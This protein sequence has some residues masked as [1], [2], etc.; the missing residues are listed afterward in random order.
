MLKRSLRSSSSKIG[1]C[2]LTN[3]YFLVPLNIKP[4][5]VKN[6]YRIQFKPLN[7]KKMKRTVTLFIVFITCISLQGQNSEV[8]NML[9]EIEGQWSLDDNSNV[10]YQRIVEVPEMK[11]D[12]IYDRVLNYF[13]YNYG[14]GKSVIQTQDN[15]KGLVI[16]KG[17]YDRLHTFSNGT[18][19]VYLGTW[20]IV[21]VD[22]K[23]GRA[24]IIITLTEYLEDYKGSLSTTNVS[25][26]FPINKDGSRKN[27]MG[28]AFYKSHLRVIETLESIEKAI[29]EGNTSK[30]IENDKW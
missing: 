2:K 1:R 29:K 8:T 30:Q 20:H 6:K 24:R 11:G 22:V 16:G 14:S 19:W 27:I 17:I 7:I 3:N 9:N 25:K 18:G 23:D 5:N 26:E 12:D 4:S 15:E 13:I 28:K 10:T 21:R